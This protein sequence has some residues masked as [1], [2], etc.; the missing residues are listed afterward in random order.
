MEIWL[1]SQVHTA[2]L[3]CKFAEKKN[4]FLQSMPQLLTQTYFLSE[5][6]LRMNC[7]PV[8]LSNEFFPEPHMMGLGKHARDAYQAPQVYPGSIN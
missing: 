8:R 4:F 6:N 7:L 1:L 2:L 5:D 3:L